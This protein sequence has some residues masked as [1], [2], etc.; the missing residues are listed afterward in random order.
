MLRRRPKLYGEAASC[1][2][3]LPKEWEGKE[4]VI[5]RLVLMEG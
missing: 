3:Y 4:V 2:V 1:A 5:V